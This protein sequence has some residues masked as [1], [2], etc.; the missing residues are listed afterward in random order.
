MSSSTHIITLASAEVGERALYDVIK[1]LYTVEPLLRGH[2]Y[3]R[4]PPLERPL[5]N[6]NCY[7]N[8]N[9]LI[10][11]PNQRSPLLKGQFSV[12]KRD[13]LTRG[14]PLYMDHHNK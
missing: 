12:A 5:N 2:P 3:E 4:P 11:A 13:G 1:Y 10:S 7:L 8:I 14:V 6:V 9:V